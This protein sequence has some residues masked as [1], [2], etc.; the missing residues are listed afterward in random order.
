M[1]NTY[2]Q[3]KQFRIAQENCAMKVTTDTCIQGAWT[4]VLPNVWKALDIGAGTGLLSLMLAQRSPHIIIDAIE[5]DRETA[6]QAE[7]NISASHWAGRI[8][9]LEGD[10]RTFVSGHKYDLIIVNPPFFHNSL[11]SDDV[12]KTNARHTLSLNY[13]ELLDAIETNLDD[14]GYISILLPYPEYELWKGL[15]EKRGW[16][17][18]GKLSISHKPQAPVKRIVGLFSIKEMPAIKEETLIIKNEEQQYTAAFKNLLAP[19]YLD[20]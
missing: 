17:E 13:H 11:H 14:N 12:R 1:S 6:E 15:L 16:N 8:N 2:F 10:A 7:D 20:L 9:V 4:P 18:C 19:F 3:F 5:L